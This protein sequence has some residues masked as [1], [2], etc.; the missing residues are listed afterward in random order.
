MFFIE[1]GLKKI[2]KSQICILEIGFGTGL[3]AFLSLLE[4]DN[5]GIEITYD[6]RWSFI[7]LAKGYMLR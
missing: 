6:A 3:N 4:S 5:R 2:R 1:A 7:R